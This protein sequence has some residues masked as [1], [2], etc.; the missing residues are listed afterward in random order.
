MLDER[1]TRRDAS[2]V[3]RRR[4]G[5]LLAFALGLVLPPRAS[6]ASGVFFKESFGGVDGHRVALAALRDRTVLWDQIAWTG[7][8]DEVAWAVPVRPGA[9]VTL[10]SD[11]WFAALDGSTQPVVYKPPKFGVAAGCMVPRRGGF[12][13]SGCSSTAFDEGPD[14][15]PVRQSAVADVLEQDLLPAGDPAALPKWLGDRGFV[16]PS[17][18]EPAI[19]AYAQDGWGFAVLRMKPRCGEHRSRVVRVVTSPASDAVVPMRLVSTNAGANTTLVL[20]TIAPTRL[21]PLGFGPAFIDIYNLAYDDTKDAAGTTPEDLSNY[22]TLVTGAFTRARGRAWLTEYAET[23]LRSTASA[24]TTRTPSVYEIY[25]PLCSG[26][27][28][29]S[30]AS[31]V[32]P[33]SL[34]SGPCT[35]PHDAGADGGDGGDG[36]VPP[37]DLGQ[38]GLR[39]LRDAGPDADGGDAGADAGPSVIPFTPDECATPDDLDVATATLDPSTLV[40]TRLRAAPGFPGYGTEDLRFAPADGTVSNELQSVQLTTDIND[41]PSKSAACDAA[42]ASGGVSYFVFAGVVALTL[43]ILRRRSTRTR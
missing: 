26:A 31:V 14:A 23:P 34:S 10:T 24:T 3:G 38:E 32:P 25:P 19:A 39:H 1:G 43:R 35:L 28:P 41:V 9:T 16:V 22:D 2:R 30:R 18:A 7:N 8:P 6:S 15:L 13:L 33:P 11:A 5:F 4:V 21:A 17:G 42:P 37:I 40:L 36:G 29:P 27:T 12:A 20:W